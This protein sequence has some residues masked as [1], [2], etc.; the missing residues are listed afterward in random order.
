MTN[1]QKALE[2]KLLIQCIYAMDHNSTKRKHEL[3]DCITRTFPPE[4]IMNLDL[5]DTKKVEPI[6]T[7]SLDKS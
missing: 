2:L 7:T 3:C 5:S 1:V 6:G 4:V